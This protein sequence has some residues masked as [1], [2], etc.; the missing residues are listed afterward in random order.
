MKKAEL[1]AATVAILKDEKIPF[2]KRE[3]MAAEYL[4]EQLFAKVK[5]KAGEPYIG[6]LRRVADGVRQRLKAAA[7]MHDVLEDIK[8]WT[9]QDLLDIG[10]SAYTVRCVEAVTKQ[11][12]EKY[13]DAMV[14]VGR[15]LPAIFIKRSDLRD[16]SNLLRLPRLPLKKDF[17]RVTKYS[18]ADKYLRDIENLIILQGTPFEDWMKAQPK[19]LQDFALLKKHTAL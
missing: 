14:R 19:E 2:E 9:A 7:L 5:D 16:N 17:N 4:V 8:G 10:F 15:T 11:P 12:G 3:E 13:F 6:H 1:K 18:L